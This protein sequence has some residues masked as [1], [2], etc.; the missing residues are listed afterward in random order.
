MNKFKNYNIK[1]LIIIIIS[2]IFIYSFLRYGFRNY[3]FWQNGYDRF[4]DFFNSVRDASVLGTY[5]ERKV[6]Y[7]PIANLFYKWIGG[8]IEHE[9]IISE[10]DSRLNAYVYPN[11]MVVFN[12]YNFV[13]TSC[14][15]VSLLKALETGGKYR[16]IGVCLILFSNPFIFAFERGNSVLICFVLVLFFKELYDSDN[17]IKQEFSLVLLA[18]AINIKI[19]PL[20]ILFIIVS[21]K[22]I[23][24]FIKTSIYSIVFFLSGF[25]F[26]NGINGLIIYLKNIFCYNSGAYNES[27]IGK[28]DIGSYFDKLKIIPPTLKNV[29]IVFFLGIAVLAIFIAEEQW[30]KWLACCWIMLNIPGVSLYYNWVF[31]SIPLIMCINDR[32][33]KNYQVIFSIL[34]LFIFAT[35]PVIV[36]NTFSYGYNAS[37]NLV[38]SCIISLIIGIFIIVL[39]LDN[40]WRIFKQFKDR[41]NKISPC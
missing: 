7:P 39:F 10:F 22:R 24:Q 8:Y 20:F 23:K 26:Y 16:Y 2:F 30:Q 33:L 9:Y 18:L 6:I 36:K 14:L 25:I 29:I 11:A 31:L 13:L 38:S 35:Y 3:N 34:I 37:L 12:I 19:Y 1:K 41:E 21:N 15:T 4:M 40:A 32:L 27:I 5:T 28:S 17:K